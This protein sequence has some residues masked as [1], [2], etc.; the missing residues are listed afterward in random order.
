MQL[1]KAV[2]LRNLVKG[3]IDALNPDAKEFVTGVCEKDIAF[4]V[5]FY[6]HSGYREAEGPSTK[7]R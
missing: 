1:I 7:T 6:M 5:N 2:E 4:L 3:K